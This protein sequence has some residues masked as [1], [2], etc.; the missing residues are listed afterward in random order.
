VGC[1]EQKIALDLRLGACVR[2]TGAHVNA[3]EP[4]SSFAFYHFPTVNLHTTPPT[5]CYSPHIMHL[6]LLHWISM[7]VWIETILRT[8][9]AVYEPVPSVVKTSVEFYNLL[10]YVGFL[11]PNESKNGHSDSSYLSRLEDLS[12]IELLDGLQR[13]I[14][15]GNVCLPNKLSMLRAPTASA[16]TATP[17]RPTRPAATMTADPL[18]VSWRMHTYIG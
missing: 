6:T 11:T 5:T 4:Y 10:W 13:L 3:N 7:C 17:S 9:K 14:G 2:E 1:S 18:R 15:R 16:L 12:Q 8:V